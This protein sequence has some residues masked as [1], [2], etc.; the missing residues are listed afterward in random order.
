MFKTGLVQKNI[1]Y[2]V[3]KSQGPKVEVF[4]V[5]MGWLK[6]G[7]PVNNKLRLTFYIYGYKCFMLGVLFILLSFNLF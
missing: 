7:A 5:Q 2:L 1:I 4:Y 3:I 6:D